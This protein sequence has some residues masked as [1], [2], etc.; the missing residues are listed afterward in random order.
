M[1]KRRIQ[2]FK[3]SGFELWE[4]TTAMPCCRV[5]GE[6]ACMKDAHYAL[7]RV[8]SNN[9]FVVYP[10]CDEHLERREKPCPS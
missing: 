4:L 1:L 10:Y 7:V 9:E 2:T 6:R 3:D 5:I 8:N